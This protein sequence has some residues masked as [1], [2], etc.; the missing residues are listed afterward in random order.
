MTEQDI[1]LQA[2]RAEVADLKQRTIP[3]AIGTRFQLPE[4]FNGRIKRM[5][6]CEVTGVDI[7]RSG[8][9]IQ[10]DDGGAMPRVINWERLKKLMG[11]G[12]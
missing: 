12:A 6:D 8:V 9:F 3:I 2:L 4:Y 1:E 5:V 11:G 7:S 10:Y